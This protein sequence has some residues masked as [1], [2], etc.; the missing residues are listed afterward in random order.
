VVEVVEVVAVAVVA[1]EEVA[2]AVV[3]VE[4]AHRPEAARLHH[5]YKRA[6]RLLETQRE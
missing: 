5:S 3:A 6:A 4:V 2:A 1:V